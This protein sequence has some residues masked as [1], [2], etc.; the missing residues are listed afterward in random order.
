MASHHKLEYTIKLLMTNNPPL[1]LGM[2]SPLQFLCDN[3]WETETKNKFMGNVQIFVFY[4]CCFTAICNLQ[5]TQSN[6]NI[7]VGFH[8]FT[9]ACYCVLIVN[10][11][12]TF[13]MNKSCW[14]SGNL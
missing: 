12:D 4:F 9:N 13:Y 1:A 6:D 7:P 2:V 8:L 10:N 14:P 11:R 5:I 3:E